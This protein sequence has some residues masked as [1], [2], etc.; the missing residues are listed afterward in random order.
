M[1]QEK[2]VSIDLVLGFFFVQSTIAFFLISGCA[3]QLLTRE[4]RWLRAYRISHRHFLRPPGKWQLLWV[5]TTNGT[6]RSHNATSNVHCTLG[7]QAACRAY[8]YTAI[9]RR[10][11]LKGR[12]WGQQLLHNK[13]LFNGR[14]FERH[15]CTHKR[16]LAGSALLLLTVTPREVETFCDVT[17]DPSR[18]GLFFLFLFF[19]YNGVSFVCL[20]Y[21]WER[22]RL[23]DNARSPLGTRWTRRKHAL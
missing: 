12:G 1:L 8:S 7:M 16:L 3:W 20:R 18:T 15:W 4:D 13:S 5:A 2:N 10:S 17:P 6:S 23:K 21:R 19:W 14:I 22:R 9:I 11:L